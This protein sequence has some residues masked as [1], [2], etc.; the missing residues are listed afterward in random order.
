[1][2]NFLIKCPSVL[3]NGG[4]STSDCAPAQVVDRS[5]TSLRA[6][7]RGSHKVCEATS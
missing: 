4:T 3:G 5:P 6:S 7:E 2:N 1:M